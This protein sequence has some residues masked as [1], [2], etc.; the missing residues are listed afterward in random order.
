MGSIL[1]LF[2]DMHCHYSSCAWE[3]ISKYKVVAVFIPERE[4]ME[5]LIEVDFQG[6]YCP[7]M[8]E[9]SFSCTG[10]LRQKFDINFSTPPIR[11][12]GLSCATLMLWGHG[13]TYDKT[14]KSQFFLAG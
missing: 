14:K 13:K 10:Y 12:H 5:S 1:P 7:C 6:G 11:L 2:A 4:D 8:V 3:Q 9:S